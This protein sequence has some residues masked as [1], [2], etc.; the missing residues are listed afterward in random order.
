M[1]D[2]SLVFIPVSWFYGHGFMWKFSTNLKWLVSV[3]PGKTEHITKKAFSLF[4]TP[5]SL[6]RQILDHKNIL[7]SG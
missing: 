5:T 4:L 3:F 2:P 6:C 1:L 7:Q